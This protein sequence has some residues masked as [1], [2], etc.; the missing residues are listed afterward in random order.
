MYFDKQKEY[1]VNKNFKKDMTSLLINT[2]SPMKE[3][4]VYQIFTEINV[5]F[6]L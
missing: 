3:I 1:K 2:Q 6:Q 4:D 5:K